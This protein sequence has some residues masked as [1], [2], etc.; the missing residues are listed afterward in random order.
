MLP[1]RDALVAAQF[2]PRAIKSGINSN[3]NCGTI[4]LIATYL[5][6]MFMY[7]LIGDGT[8]SARNRRYFFAFNGLHVICR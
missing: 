6:I 4:A 3:C 1:P 5:V 2:F 7:D 8:V